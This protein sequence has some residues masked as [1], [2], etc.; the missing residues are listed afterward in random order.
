MKRTT[1]S[2]GFS[3]MLCLHK[4]TNPFRSYFC[5]WGL[6]QSNESKDAVSIKCLFLPDG[7]SWASF[8]H[9]ALLTNN[10]EMTMSSQSPHEQC[11]FTLR[12]IKFN[13]C[14]LLWNI[15]SHKS[16][17]DLHTEFWISLQKNI[18]IKETHTDLQTFTQAPSAGFIILTKLLY[19]APFTLFHYL[20]ILYLTL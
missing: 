4:N 15:T 12:H 1:P 10:K 7:G 5:V 13:L 20:T 6:T 8:R 14:A 3:V 2:N 9:T 17:M 19:A 11:A 16:Q 18:G